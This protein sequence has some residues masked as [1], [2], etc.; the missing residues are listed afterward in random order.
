MPTGIRSGS[1][2]GRSR[3]AHHTPHEP[4]PRADP[5]A[6]SRHLV[7]VLAR[8]VG[9]V[10]IE[11][12]RRQE[13]RYDLDS[14]LGRELLYLIANDEWIHTTTEVID[15]KKSSTVDT[16]IRVEVNPDRITHEAFRESRDR[17]WLPLL[18]LPPRV[19]ADGTARRLTAAVPIVTDGTGDILSTLPQLQVRRWVSAALA[20]IVLNSATGWFSGPDH[21]V[22]REL[23]LVLSDA[24]WRT[25]QGDVGEAASIRAE[26]EPDNEDAAQGSP[27]GASDVRSPQH[28]TL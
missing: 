3:F 13:T 19:Q 7:G 28:R 20:E 16:T 8:A 10:T 14:R 9:A 1:L 5:L 6:R 22:T 4:P 18:V 27:S 24:L 21:V 26:D 15:L 23:R 12:F 2:P 25:L 11:D 17:L